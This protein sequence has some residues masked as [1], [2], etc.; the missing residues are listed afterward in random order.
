M[1]AP[2]GGLTVTLSDTP[3]VTLSDTVTV[4]TTDTAYIGD[5][6]GE[7][8]RRHVVDVACSVTVRAG[9]CGQR[10]GDRDTVV[11]VAARKTR[12]TGARHELINGRR[13]TR[14]EWQRLRDRWQQ[15]LPQPC[16]RCDRDIQPWDPWDLDHV[17]VPVALGATD[18][19]VR[20][21][22]RQCNQRA[23]GEL[24]QALTQLGAAVARGDVDPGFL[25]AV[26]APATDRKSVV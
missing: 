13:V 6:V 10:T 3:T 25:E 26:T 15:R 17:G 18:V 19:D 12:R 20:P 5:T 11:G 16:P 9:H 22:H 4:S 21:A 23:G 8:L 1:P 2:F 7:H 14:Q 24:S